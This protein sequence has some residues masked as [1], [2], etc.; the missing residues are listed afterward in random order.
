[1]I[2]FNMFCKSHHRKNRKNQKQRTKFQIQESN[3]Q[4][5]KTNQK[6]EIKSKVQKNA[7]MKY[8]K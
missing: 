6:L 3:K 1:M 7:R 4:E 5:K 2:K 8:E